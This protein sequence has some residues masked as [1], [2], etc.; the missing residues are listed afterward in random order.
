MVALVIS[1]YKM[2][3]MESNVRITEKQIIFQNSAVSE[4]GGIKLAGYIRQSHGY[5]QGKGRRLGSYALVYSLNGGCTYRDERVGK[6]KIQAGDL[7]FLY[8][9]VEHRY[10]A[11]PRGH[12]DE[13]FIVFDGPVFDL[14]QQSGLF[15]E[16]HPVLRL[17][18]VKYWQRRMESCLETRGTVGRQA[19]LQQVCNLQVLLLEML[20][21]NQ[22]GSTDVLRP[23]WLQSACKA[24]G[25][26]LGRQILLPQLAESLHVSFETFRKKFTVATGMSPGRYRAGKQIDRACELM[27]NANLSGKEI[28]GELGFTDE[29]HFS[30]RFKQI[31]G[32]TPSQFRRQMV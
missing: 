32:I 8:P 10:G 13:F 5:D 23:D 2:A 29:Y 27:V 4:L 14:W 31:T 24:L 1:L 17:Q 22:R 25:E 9:Q 15:P 16:E 12:W 30:K 11:G 19:A 26:N 6:L 20:E 3:M 21:S 18:P 7:I 28:A